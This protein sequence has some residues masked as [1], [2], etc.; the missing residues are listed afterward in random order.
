MVF[1]Q[2]NDCGLILLESLQAYDHVLE[3]E[4][5]EVVALQVVHETVDQVAFLKQEINLELCLQ[6]A[7]NSEIEVVPDFDLG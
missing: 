1:E 5:V 2:L 4:V 6:A 7:D 3:D